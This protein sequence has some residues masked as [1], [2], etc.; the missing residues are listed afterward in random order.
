[1]NELQVKLDTLKKFMKYLGRTKIEIH[2]VLIGYFY[3]RVGLNSSAIAIITGEGQYP[4]R[5]FLSNRLE[6]FLDISNVSI[7]EIISYPQ[8]IGGGIFGF[9]TPEPKQMIL[10]LDLEIA[11]IIGAHLYMLCWMQ[12]LPEFE[13]QESN[14]KRERIKNFLKQRLDY[15]GV[16][17]V[18][19]SKENDVDK[20]KLGREA[21]NKFVLGL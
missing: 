16:T 1:M 20:E 6:I 18:N 12:A 5:E 17:I 14:I 2:D 8:T 19:D 15:P 13:A 7:I 10:D 3:S 4:S 9:I 11:E 21:F